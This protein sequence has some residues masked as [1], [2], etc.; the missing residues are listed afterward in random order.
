MW[1]NSFGS[2]LAW[3]VGTASLKALDRGQGKLS[4]IIGA[5]LEHRV[6]LELCPP[7]TGFR[8]AMLWNT[9]ANKR[10]WSFT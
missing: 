8:V 10:R 9:D 7:L 4:E 2:P 1:D 6:R 5:I 3:P